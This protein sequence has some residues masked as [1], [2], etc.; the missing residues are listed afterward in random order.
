MNPITWIANKRL[1]VGQT[2]FTL[3]ETLVGL[4]IMIGLSSALVGSLYQMN[5]TASRGSAQ[6]N[7][8]SDW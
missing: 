6:A 7:Q 3:L 4:S 1:P 2:G 5:G 8:Q